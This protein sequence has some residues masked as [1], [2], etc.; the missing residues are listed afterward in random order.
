ME[1]EEGNY[2]EDT[3]EGISQDIRYNDFEEPSI[4]G[5]PSDIDWWG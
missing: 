3:E 4:Y 5:Q 1:N 2:E